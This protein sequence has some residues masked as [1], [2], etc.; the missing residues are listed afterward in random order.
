[1]KIITVPIGFDKK[2]FLRWV[3]YEF[4][5]SAA[6]RWDVVLHGK[7]TSE[8]FACKNAI[9]AQFVRYYERYASDA[10]ISWDDIV[11]P[12]DMGRKDLELLARTRKL[13][14]KR[15][16]YEL[17]KT[18]TDRVYPDY[19]VISIREARD[20]PAEPYLQFSPA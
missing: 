10:G 16:I 7:A 13:D 2:E 11:Y 20:A 6:K 17:S 1:M 5:L 8:M 3:R 4:T 19:E 15:I 18:C 9:Q 14:T 12:N